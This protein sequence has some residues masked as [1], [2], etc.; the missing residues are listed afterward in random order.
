MF[1]FL[2]GV[3]LGWT[4]ARALPPKPPEEPILKVPSTNELQ[5]L[6]Q[7]VLNAMEAIKKKLDESD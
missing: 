6:A 1:K 4:A 3:T 5:I 2:S 7:Q